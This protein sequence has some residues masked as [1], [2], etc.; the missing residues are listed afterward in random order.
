MLSMEDQKDLVRTGVSRAV[1]D[2]FGGYP[3]ERMKTLTKHFATILGD[4]LRP[5]L[6]QVLKDS[7]PSKS[8][9][10]TCVSY[11]RGDTVEVVPR[12]KGPGATGARGTLISFSEHHIEVLV[13]ARGP[14]KAL[15]ET[16][17]MGNVAKVIIV[18]V[19]E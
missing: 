14:H 8:I 12:T 5:A 13:P 17:P 10:S 7:L 9:Y 1:W 15:K 18:Q 6:I 2:I 3:E 4:I 19:E 16:F 11:R